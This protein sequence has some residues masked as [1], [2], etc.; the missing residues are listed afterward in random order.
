MAS[1]D[2][3]VSAGGY[4]G[5]KL[6][7]YATNRDL[8]AI[9]EMLADDVLGSQREDA[10]VGNSIVGVLQIT[11][12]PYL[13]YKGGWRALIEGVR[14]SKRFRLSGVGREMVEWA[15][16]RAK[17]RRCILLQ[18]TT[19]KSRPDAIRF[20]N[21]LGFVASHEGMKLKP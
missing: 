17:E 9:V 6:I 21:N 8:T 14:V 7:R 19:D 11:F 10:S 16:T 1:E 5:R 2:P 4:P 12:I 15:I 18:L 13:T 3:R 20:Y